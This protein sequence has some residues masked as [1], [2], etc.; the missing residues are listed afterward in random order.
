ML[1][2]NKYSGFV[3]LSITLY[4]VL[5]FRGVTLPYVG[6]NSW[7]FN[8]YSHIAQNYLRFGFLET[9][10]APVT[11]LAE[12][13]PANPSYYLHHPQLLYV[14]MGVFYQVLGADHWVGRLPV[15]LAS[16]GSLLILY[17][18]GFFFGNRM[19]ATIVVGVAALIPAASIFGKM[20]GHE[21]FVLFFALGALYAMLLYLR[22][23]WWGHAAVLYIAI[24]L[25]TL[26]DWPMTYFTASL[27]LFL[28]YKKQYKLAVG[29]VAVTTATA[30]SL[31]LYIYALLGGLGD[32]TQAFSVR[33]TG[34]L[35]QQSYWPL[36]WA[37]T[38]LLRLVLYFNPLFLFTACVYIANILWKK[39]KH[40]ESVLLS[41]LLLFPVI[42]V[43]LYPE[44]SFGHAYWV[45][46]FLPFVALAAAKY[47]TE[48]LKKKMRLHVAA[49]FVFSFVFLLVISNWKQKEIEGNLFRYELAKKAD[50]KIPDAVPVLFH[51]NVLIDK[52]LFEYEFRHSVMYAP[53]PDGG[54][55]KARYYVF[56][57]TVRCSAQD[58]EFRNLANKFEG[59]NAITPEA[60]LY[61]F[62]LDKK[63]A[64]KQSESYIAPPKER[65]SIQKAERKQYNMRDIY[66]TL[67]HMLN[68]PQL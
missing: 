57:C 19:Y 12:S 34:A 56:T 18:I 31:L 45:Y 65:Q 15:I 54:Q 4:V 43:L 7:N 25:G 68:A 51:S 5:L 20:I 32:L 44:G 50:E 55:I 53:V 58:R 28:I 16:I 33:S 27:A 37:G 3:F 1:K 13:L 39:M 59:S 40:E 30:A 21:A 8:T 23:G 61:V 11:S 10:F 42:H 17:R 49:V 29:T 26:S 48:I 6:Y 24:I 64:G 62:D 14:T 66:D 60:E 38:I 67:K 36:R 52:D 63:I 22:S 46:Y 47:Y 35:L 41:V 9:R 2:R